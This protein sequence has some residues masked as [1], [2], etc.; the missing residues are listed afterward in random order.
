MS[1]TYRSCINTVERRTLLNS[2]EGQPSLKRLG[3]EEYEALVCGRT[4]C[5]SEIHARY[6]RVQFIPYAS[7]KDNCDCGSVAH[8]PGYSKFESDKR[9]RNGALDARVSPIERLPP[10]RDVSL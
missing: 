3:G 9:L 7:H 10:E 6:I 4:G 8:T 1:T 5:S 2:C